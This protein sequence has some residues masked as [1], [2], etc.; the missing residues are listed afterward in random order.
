MLATGLANLA[1]IGP[2]TVKIMHERKVQE[3]R[4][5]KKYYD[6]GPKSDSM[7]ALNKRF[8]MA[9]GASSLL[10]L[11]GLLATGWYGVVLGSKL[12]F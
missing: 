2:A 3:T 9:H 7:A 10:N 6:E 4:E 8:G 11:V 12:K 1:I 5:G